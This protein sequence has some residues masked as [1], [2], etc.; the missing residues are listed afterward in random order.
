MKPFVFSNQLDLFQLP[1]VE[2]KPV[3]VKKPVPA[4][5][6][7]IPDK[8]DDY[9]TKLMN[10]YEQWLLLPQETLIREGSP[11][12]DRV[13]EILANGYCD[14]YSKALHRCAKLPA[15][16]EIWLN[17][18]DKDYWV[19]HTKGE[20]QGDKCDVCPYCGAKLKDGK[21]DVVLIKA[22]AKRYANYKHWN[23]DRFYNYREGV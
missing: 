6:I 4:K 1:I 14:L 5:P 8:Q 21:G 10:T 17:H 11:E 9:L 7:I 19:I 16:R 23:G 13:R 20:P 3:Q 22:E 12:R 2:A 18:C 15:H